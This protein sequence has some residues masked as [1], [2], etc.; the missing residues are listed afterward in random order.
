[1]S[2]ERSGRKGKKNGKKNGKKVFK[3]E[4]NYRRK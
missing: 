4:E 2:K 3:D 1:M